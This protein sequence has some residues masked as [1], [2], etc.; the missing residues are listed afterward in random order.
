L[1]VF[2]LEGFFYF[3]SVESKDVILELNAYKFVIGN[4]YVFIFSIV[5]I[6]LTSM[7]A[8][9]LI[10]ICINN[11]D[12][13]KKIKLSFHKINFTLVI[14]LIVLSIL[15]IL[16]N[17]LYSHFFSAG[18]FNIFTHS[19]NN[20]ILN[21]DILP[22][23]FKLFLIIIPSVFLIP[24]ISI[25]NYYKLHMKITKIVDTFVREFLYIDYLM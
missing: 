21:T 22:F 25:K 5:T 13:N 24:H 4:N 1:G 2:S 18:I 3:S 10:D 23:Y 11:Y 17:F 20:Q 9:N 8:S 14:P 6:F 7:Y 12:F 19:V 15:T 16:S